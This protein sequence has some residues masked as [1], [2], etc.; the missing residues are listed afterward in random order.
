[1]KEYIPLVAGAGALA[2]RLASHAVSLDEVAVE[3]ERRLEPLAGDALGAPVGELG[4]GVVVTLD[5]VL[6]LAVL[7]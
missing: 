1:M 5:G 3:E 2:P 4:A 7:G 6:L